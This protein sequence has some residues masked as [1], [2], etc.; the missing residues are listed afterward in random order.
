M[1]D[2]RKHLSKC[3]FAIYI[4]THFIIGLF[5]FLLLSFKHSLCILDNSLLSGMCFANVF[6]VLP[7]NFLNSVFGRADIFNFSEVQR[8]NFSFMDYAFGVL[9]K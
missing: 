4:S 2:D 6:W 1:T 5:T 3:L 9:S 8:I 7:F